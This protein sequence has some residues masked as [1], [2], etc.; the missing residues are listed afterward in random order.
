MYFGVNGE[1]VTLVRSVTTNDV[2]VSRSGADAHSTSIPTLRFPSRNGR[3]SPSIRSSAWRGTYWTESLDA[4]KE[5][6]DGADRPS[7]L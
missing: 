3:S 6:V 5:Q 4:S 7:L 1:Y 2:K